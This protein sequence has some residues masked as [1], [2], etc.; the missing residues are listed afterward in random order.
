M[1]D[2]S[3]PAVPTSSNSPNYASYFAHMAELR[4][5][6]AELL[7]ANKAALFDALDAAGIVTV[8]ITFDGEGD[9]GQIEDV[10]VRNTEGDVALPDAHIEFASVT[11]FDADPKRRTVPVEEALEEMAYSFLRE[12]HAGW[13]NNDGAYGEFTFDVTNRTISLNYNERYLSVETH[14]HQF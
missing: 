1:T 3:Q 5:R 11:R 9:S 6:E 4:R 10:I 14:D 2:T 8:V 13:E 7:P 12:A